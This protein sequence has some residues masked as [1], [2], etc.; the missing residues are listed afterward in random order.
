[1]ENYKEF[2]MQDVAIW[3]MINSISD[4]KESFENG[5]DDRQTLQ[6][7]QNTLLETDRWIDRHILELQKS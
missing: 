2:N 3:N 4:V 7:L 6:E 5:E 1:M